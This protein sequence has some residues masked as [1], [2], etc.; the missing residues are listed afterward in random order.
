LNELK[1]VNEIKDHFQTEK[2]TISDIQ[3][4]EL[5]SKDFI[6]RISEDIKEKQ[7]KITLY[8]K[9]LKDDIIT[10]TQEKDKLEKLIKDKVRI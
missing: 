8:N 6:K 4:K 3:T 9:K 10:I 7:E 2:T 5:D 1:F